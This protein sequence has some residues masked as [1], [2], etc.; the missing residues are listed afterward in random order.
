MNLTAELAQFKKEK[1]IDADIL[2]LVTSELELLHANVLHIK[3][4][5]HKLIDGVIHTLFKQFLTLFT[6][7]LVKNN[8]IMGLQDTM[9]QQDVEPQT[10]QEKLTTALQ[11]IGQ[12]LGSLWYIMDL[13]ELIKHTIE[14]GETEKIIFMLDEV[15][16]IVSAIL[17]KK[18]N[19]ICYYV[20]ERVGEDIRFALDSYLLGTAVPLSV[21][22]DVVPSGVIYMGCDFKLSQIQT[23]E[24]DMATIP[25]QKLV[26]K[27][28]SKYYRTQVDKVV[29]QYK[30]THDEV[31]QAE[32]H[33][34]ILEL[35]EAY[36]K[37]TDV[38]LSIEQ[39]DI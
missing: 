20:S 5:D 33:S 32:L 19:L 39:L 3:D 38:P 27:S 31:V 37:H 15:D 1:D 24:L 13:D 22:F 26:A 18:Y 7:V 30:N 34:K 35:I 29:I 21:Y 2:E 11:D 14:H 10:I 12:Q 23:D 6:D 8:A 16:I 9:V 28:M 4:T 36:N 25:V 17:L